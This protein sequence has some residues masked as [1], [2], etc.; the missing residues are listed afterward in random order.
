M[1]TV[2]ERVVK[3]D[4]EVKVGWKRLSLNDR[5]W[6]GGASWGRDG[7]THSHFGTTKV[8]TRKSNK[9]QILCIKIHIQAY[10]ENRI[11]MEYMIRFTQVHETFR[12]A[13]IEALAVLEGIHLE[14]LSY[15]PSVSPVSS[16]PK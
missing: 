13:E 9:P 4:I 1:P 3:F 10:E 5:D 15:S 12:L 11:I 7:L 16:L 2:E 14:V 8:T 6:I